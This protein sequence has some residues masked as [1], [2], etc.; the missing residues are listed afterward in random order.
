MK[1]RPAR[2]VR[3]TVQTAWLNAALVF[4]GFVLSPSVGFGQTASEAVDAFIHDHMQQRRIPGLALAVI[5][6]GDIVKQS[7]YGV[8][9][10][11]SERPVTL[12]TPFHVASISKNVTAVGVMML[13]EEGLLGLD[14]EIGKH[15]QDI[16]HHW[17][18]IT[19]RQLLTHTS[20]LPDIMLDPFSTFT[21]AETSEDA[22][23]LLVDR[24]LEFT[25]G[26]EWRYNQTNSMVLALF[27]ETLTNLSYED[28]VLERM[29][30]PIGVHSAFFGES[31]VG[32]TVYTV[33]DFSGGE[34][35]VMDGIEP[36]HQSIK[37]VL[38]PA[39]GLNMTVVDFVNWLT[40]FLE[41]R[42]I[43]KASVE[44][45]WTPTQLNDGTVFQ[46]ERRPGSP[47]W[48]AYGLGWAIRPDAQPPWVGGAGG[49]RAAFV[50]Y[51]D[52]DL[53]VTVFTNLQGARPE[54][55]ATTVAQ[56]YLPG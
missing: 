54:A 37:P 33:F 21:I 5:Q 24:P 9:N 2:W 44:S 29:F 4:A 15:L 25:P 16:P 19:V 27:I 30:A 22:M 43:T 6:S 35:Q 17:K 40:A 26:G 46:L 3:N 41:G 56:H 28:F 8:T 11:L 12:A 38:Y 1:N 14:D 32:P 55:I 23:A 36:L 20:G 53:A 18:P 31:D 13:V 34:P 48:T 45:L 7:A 50:I 47:Q 52:H 49:L 51:P 10:V 39:G 42:F